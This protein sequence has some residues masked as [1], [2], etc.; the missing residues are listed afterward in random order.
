MSA[1]QQMKFIGFRLSP[2]MASKVDAVLKAESRGV[3]EYV[4]DL[5]RED[6]R[7]RGLI[8]EPV[9]SSTREVGA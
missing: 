8:K 5:V 7:K 1:S 9:E 3:T 2:D 4:R 6:L